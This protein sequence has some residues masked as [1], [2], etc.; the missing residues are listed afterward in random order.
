M[1]PLFI[2]SMSSY[3]GKNMIGLGLSLKL[4]D[5]G[6][7][8]GYFKPIGILPT[9]EE[10][11][12]TDEDVKFFRQALDLTDPIESMCPIVLTESVVN[13]VFSNTFT[14]AIDKIRKAFETVSKDKDIML[15]GGMGDLD[16]GTALSASGAQIIEAL[17]AKAIMVTKYLDMVFCTDRSLSTQTHLGDRLVGIVVNRATRRQGEIL[18]DKIIPFLTSKGVNILGVIR[19]DPL[20]GAVPVSE[21]VEC[22]H[23]KVLCAESHLDALVERFSI[24]AMNVESALRFFQRQPN[25]GVIVGGDRPD[26][27]LAALETSTRC[28]ILTGDLHPNEI[29]LGKAEEKEIPILLVK[30]DTATTVDECEDLLGHL[31]LRSMEKVR[32]VSEVFESNIDHDLIYRKLG[33]SR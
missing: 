29:I 31:S 1:I 12:I 15:I 10:N 13:K 28:L 30:S 6:Y 33:L 16:L 3:S 7:K 9:R 32:R 14:G 18:E 22:L 23:A 27:Q 5:D 2:G 19:E 20:L 25:K 8:V 24:G 4:K 21:L 26:I 11:L 17:D